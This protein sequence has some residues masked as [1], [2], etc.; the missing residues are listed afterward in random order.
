MNNTELKK[1][2][3]LNISM[4]TDFL[5]GS[6]TDKHYVSTLKMIVKQFDIHDVSNIV[7]LKPPHFKQKRMTEKAEKAKQLQSIGYSIREIMRIMN[8]KSP[9]SIQDLLKR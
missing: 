9:K 5:V 8:Y 3:E 2:A 4:S 6:I 1:Y 7:D